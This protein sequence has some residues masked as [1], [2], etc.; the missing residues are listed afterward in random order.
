MSLRTLS[1]R[2][3]LGVL[4]VLAAAMLAGIIYVH[5]SAS[6]WSDAAAARTAIAGIL[7]AIEQAETPPSAPAAE[8]RDATEAEAAEIDKVANAYLRAL[9]EADLEGAWELLHPDSRGELTLEQWEQQRAKAIEAEAWY[10]D[11]LDAIHLLMLGD[12]FELGEI[13]TELGR[14]WARIVMT[15]EAPCTLMIRKAGD[16]WAVDLVATRDAEA[17]V[18]I[19]RQLENFSEGEQTFESLMMAMMGN[20]AG[21]VPVSITDLVRLP[22]AHHR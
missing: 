3:Q 10:Q 7:A 20:E 5:R 21:Y 2:A 13:I 11:E 12:D 16:G 15:V 6:A 4:I 1:G 14:G 18:V 19:E 22:I 17:R 9:E 8:G